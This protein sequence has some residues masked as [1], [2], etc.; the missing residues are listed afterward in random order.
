MWVTVNRHSKATQKLDAG[1]SQTGTDPA[2][3]RGGLWAE[4]RRQL[5]KLKPGPEFISI[6]P[7]DEQFQNI[8]LIFQCGLN[9]NQVQIIGRKKNTE[10]KAKGITEL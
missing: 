4:L 5:D 2:Q 10:S 7:S 9:N 3:I 8:Y 1:H 6:R